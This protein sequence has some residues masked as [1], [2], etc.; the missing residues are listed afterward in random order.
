MYEFQTI[1]QSI[2]EDKIKKLTH[3]FYLQVKQTPELLA[4]YPE[5]LDPAEER[6]FLFL[7]QVF[8]GPQTYS[9]MRGHPM[10]RKRH[11]Q[12]AIDGNMRNKWLNCMFAAMDKV[13][14]DQN[15]REAMLKY[16]VQVANHMVNQ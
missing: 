14:M 15:T 16:F 2:G 3:L 12:W 11:F 9:E 4:L 8:G 1:Y 13:E 6:L 10:L 7:Q 5:E